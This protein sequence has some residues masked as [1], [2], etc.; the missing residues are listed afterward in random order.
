MSDEVST[1][2]QHGCCERKTPSFFIAI[3]TAF[4]F[5]YFVGFILRFGKDILGFVSPVM[6]K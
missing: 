5:T 2:Y 6:V 4:G 1:V 3:T